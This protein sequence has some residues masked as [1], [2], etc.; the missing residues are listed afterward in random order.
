MTPWF[1]PWARRG[2]MALLGTT[3]LFGAF[4]AWGHSH[5]HSGAMSEAEVVRMKER[6]LERARSELSLNEAQQA[7]LGVLADALQQQRQALKGDQASPREALQALIA[8]PQFDRS[9]A[10][11]L[12]DAKTAALKTG[13]PTV[14]NA[15]ADFYDSLQPEQQAKVRDFLARGGAHR[16]GSRLG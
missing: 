14:L 4:S 9:G 5:C 15:L 10:Q 3:V 11:A 7:K 16:F 13:A 6:V 12:L 2:L 1:K 8:G